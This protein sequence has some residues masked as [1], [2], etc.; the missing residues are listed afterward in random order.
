MDIGRDDA[1]KA[2]VNDNMV[3]EPVGLFETWAE[4]NGGKL[5]TLGGWAITDIV[6][7]GNKVKNLRFPRERRIRHGRGPRLM[8]TRMDFCRLHG[9]WTMRRH[10][11][12]SLQF[13][14]RGANGES[15]EKIFEVKVGDEFRPI[16][17]T[18]RD[19]QMSL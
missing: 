14:Q 4:I 6:V 7:S 16:V 18:G 9:R 3:G 10:P 2:K 1:T 13:G 5:S 19:C 15:P 12:M 11:G 17:R 8:I